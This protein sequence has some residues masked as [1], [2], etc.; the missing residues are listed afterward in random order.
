MSDSVV[1]TTAGQ[2]R[3][4]AENGLLV[5]RSVPYAAS[6]AGDR[7]LRPP[8]PVPA[9]DGVRDATVTGHVAPQPVMPTQLLPGEQFEQGEDCLALNVWTPGADGAGRPVLVWI[10]GGAFVTGSGSGAF[11]DGASLARRGDVVVVTINYR[12]GVLG[13]LAHPDLRDPQTGAAGNWGLLDQIAS[14]RWVQ[15]NIADFGGDPGKVTIF[16]ESAGSMSVSTLLGSPPAAG[17]FR[18]AIAESGGAAGVPMDVAK[19]TA[20]AVA[21]ALGLGADEVSKLRDAPVDKILEAQTK[22]TLDRRGTGGP[23]PFAPVVDG[24]VLTEHAQQAVAG[25]SAAGVSLLIGSNLDEW[26][27]FALM[28]PSS[29]DVD[30]AGLRKRIR[31]TVGERAEEL[32]DGYTKAREARGASVEATELLNAI[33]SDHM[34]RV[35]GMQLA[36]AQSV[37][38]PRTFAY[39]FTYATPAMG[40][41]LGSCHAL[42]IPF[43]FG[44]HTKPGVSRFAG[45]GPEVAALSERMQEAWLA[46]ARTGDPS[47]SALGEWP[48]YEPGR[49]ATMILGPECRV[50]DAPLEDERRLWD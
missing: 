26:K 33:E 28:D 36:E 5:F 12:L 11:Y 38:Q 44:T 19:E 30:D 24:A 18:G 34:F 4:S 48:R 16:G 9:W 14:L 13:F 32:V 50:E 27:L 7:R 10:H 3:G 31:A 42:E 20:E 8:Q 47:T 49:R 46:F 45:D 43:V 37:H 22:V 29:A 25:G 15:D 23:L 2:V 40:G 35:P 1:S 41:K 17:L 6:P 39:L 21:A